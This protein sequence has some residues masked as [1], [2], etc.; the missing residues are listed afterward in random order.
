VSVA[1]P[2]PADTGEYE[3]VLG[4]TV[5]FG[6]RRNVLTFDATMLEQR[7]PQTVERLHATLKT[8]GDRELAEVE[9]RSDIVAAVRHQIASTFGTDAA[10]D[11]EAVAAAL[12]VASRALQWRLGQHETTYERIL[13]EIRRDV[14]ERMLREG[15]APMT[16]IAGHLRF[17][18]LSAFTRAAHRWF[19]MSPSEYRRKLRSDGGGVG[20]GTSAS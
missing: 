20:G 14:A 11:L 13:T 18:E 7:I 3:R 5:R 4:T 19:G 10:F 17:S 15:R 9:R 6:E 16:E 12:G 8:A 1:E 2:L